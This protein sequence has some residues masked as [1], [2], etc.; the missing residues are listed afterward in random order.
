MKKIHHTHILQFTNDIQFTSND[1]LRS[2]SS[3][4]DKI[5]LFVIKTKLSHYWEKIAIFW[6]CSSEMLKS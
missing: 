4:V 5:D 2:L 1:V 6:D 3:T